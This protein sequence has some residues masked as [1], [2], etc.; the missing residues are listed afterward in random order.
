M[1]IT[2]SYEIVFRE[3]TRTVIYEKTYSHVFKFL[4]IIVYFKKAHWS[5]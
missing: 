2:I 5:K 3:I 4:L 1:E